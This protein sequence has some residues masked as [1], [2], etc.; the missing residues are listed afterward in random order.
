MLRIT[1]DDDVALLPLAA[2]RPAAATYVFALRL[3]ESFILSS[4]TALG[5]S[6][7]LSQL[8]QHRF[9]LGPAMVYMHP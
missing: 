8:L 9:Q 6:I 5:C 2:F 4:H 3:Y 1:N 7:V